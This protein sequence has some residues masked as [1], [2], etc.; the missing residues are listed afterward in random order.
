MMVF[1]REENVFPPV[2]V[3]AM[4]ASYAAG[5]AISLLISGPLSDRFGRKVVMLPAPIIGLVGSTLIAVGETTE[6]PMLIGRILS[7]VSIGIAM[8]AGGSWVKELSSPPFEELPPE[9]AGA[10]RATMALTGGFAVG[11]L[12]AG[13]LAEWGPFPGRL[14][15]IIHIVLS[16]GTFMGMVRIPET[17]QTAHSKVKGSLWS[18]LAVPSTKHPRFL[19]AVLPIAPW[20]FGAAGVSYAIMPSL[21]QDHVGPAIAF[22]AFVTAMALAFGFGA[23]QIAHRIIQPHNARGQQAALLLVIIGMLIA[24]WTAA[25][26]SVIGVILVGAV[27]GPAYG[28]ALITGLTEVQ[29]IAGP[30]DLGG[31]TAVFYVFTYVGFFFP[32]ILTRASSWFSYPVML[33]AGAGMAVLALIVTTIFSSRYIPKG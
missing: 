25:T 22:S 27:L 16:V 14:P 9:G 3:D 4:L 7:G 12:V 28:L 20:V 18:D 30:N 24:A 13:L 33:G 31:L 29:R 23:Q 17:R 32:M 21:A 26:T 19:L 10:R 11:A 8:S 5:I 2:F 15:Y 6:L 1:Y